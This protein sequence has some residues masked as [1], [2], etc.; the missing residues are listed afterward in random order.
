MSPL[1]TTNWNGY[2]LLSIDPGL[3]CTGWAAYKLATIGPQLMSCGKVKSEDFQDNDE[4]L[5]VRLRPII[6]CMRGVSSIYRPA[7]VLIEQPPQTIY[8]ARMLKKDMIVARAQSVF[9]VFA[10]LGA[11]IADL[12]QVSCVQHVATILPS[13][14]EYSKKKRGGMDVKQWSLSYANSVIAGRDSALGL[15][16][17]HTKEDQNVADAISLGHIAATMR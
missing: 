12:R 10:V 11:L 6:D 2:S 3:V 7:V 16:H 14:W 1:G 17:L 9:K 5:I 15:P 8:G 13:Q 4:D